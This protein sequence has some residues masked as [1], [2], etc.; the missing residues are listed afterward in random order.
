[1]K[2]VIQVLFQILKELYIVLCVL[3]VMFHTLVI[4]A[5]NHVQKVLSILTEEDINV[6]LVL[7]AHIVTKK[8]V[9]DVLLVL[10]E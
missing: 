2:Y 5:V 7:Q 6:C 1:M 8:E 4:L 3:L 9:P 10:M